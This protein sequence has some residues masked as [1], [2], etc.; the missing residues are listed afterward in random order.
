MESIFFKA[1][2]EM[3]NDV[4]KVAGIEV[5]LSLKVQGSLLIAMQKLTF[6]M[7]F[8]LP[9]KETLFLLQHRT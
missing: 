9:W 6:K 7:N 5:L 2:L 4:Q 1:E 8:W 3:L